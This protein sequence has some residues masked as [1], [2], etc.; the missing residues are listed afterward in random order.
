MMRRRCRVDFVGRGAVVFGFGLFFVFGVASALQPGVKTFRQ[1]GA[2]VACICVHCAYVD[3]CKAYHVIE[4]KHAQ[5]HVSA[6]PDF[7]PTNPTVAIIYDQTTE[8]TELDVQACDSFVEEKGRWAK[9]MPP[10]TL[11]KAGFDPDFVPT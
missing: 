3:R 9:M 2:P 10:G 11:V 1:R 5:P 8:L 7:Q 4:E 6:T